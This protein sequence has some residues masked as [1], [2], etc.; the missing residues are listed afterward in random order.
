[1]KHIEYWLANDGTKFS[2][3]VDCKGYELEQK[4]EYS[5]LK[6]LR[7]GGGG[8][9]K[10]RTIMNPEVYNECEIVIVES[11]AA[12]D[13][14]RE[15]QNFSGFYMEINSVGKWKYDDVGGKWVKEV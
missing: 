6:V 8:A 9:Y 13:D 4:L 10:N 14:L 5:T 1:M 2:N 7:S 11:Q 3:M 15:V 12:L